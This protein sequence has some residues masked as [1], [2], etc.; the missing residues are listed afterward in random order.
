MKKSEFKTWWESE[1]LNATWHKEREGIAEVAFQAGISQAATEAAKATGTAVYGCGLGCK[2]TAT[3]KHGECN[4]DHSELSFKVKNPVCQ[5]CKGTGEQDS[6]GVYPWGEG[7]N[8]PCDC[9]AAR[10]PAPVVAVKTWQE[11]AEDD[12]AHWS[13]I[14][15]RPYM[16]QEIRD[17]RAALA[18][19]AAPVLSDEQLDEI[20]EKLDGA[21][22]IK[23]DAIINWDRALRRAYARKIIAATNPHKE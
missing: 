8:V 21:E 3:F 17:L 19:T 7:I 6:G 18:A 22:I 23:S 20:W 10:Q 5:K 14:D 16:E 2:C 12:R 13:Q 1:G 11:R 4:A 15:A 9:E